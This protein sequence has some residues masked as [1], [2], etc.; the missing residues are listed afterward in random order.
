MSPSTGDTMLDEMLGGGVPAGRTLLVRGPSGVGKSR[1]AMGFLDA[2]ADA[3]EDCLYVTTD[4]PLSVARA[5]LEPADGVTLAAVHRDTSGGGVRFVTA[6]A[7][8]TIPFGSLIERLTESDWSRLAVDGAGGLVDLA[9]DRER[10]RHGRFHLLERLDEHETT[11]VLTATP[12]ASSAVARLAHGVLDCWREEIEGDA[13]PFCRVEKLRGRDHD[14][15]RHA[16]AHDDDGVTVSAREWATHEDPFR[17]GIASLD[18]LTG[19]FV[20]NGTTLFEHDGTADHWPFSA[21]LAARAVE[22]DAPV[23]VVTAPGTLGNRV[24]DLLSETV[25]P[26]T[27]LMERNLLYLIDPVSRSPGEPAVAGLETDSVVLQEAEGSIQEAFRTLVAELGG[28]VEEAV[29]IIEHS[30]MAHLVTENEA[31]QLYYWAD[32]NVMNG[33]YDLTLV[34]TIDRAVAGDRLTAFFSGAADQVVRTWRGDDELQY[35]SVPKSPAGTPGHTR[36]VE[37]LEAPPY[38]ELR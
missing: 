16:L 4:E 21:A 11:A 12:A 25:A 13:R 23:V 37:P 28:R 9:P 34:L 17:T 24:D 15:R 36:V 31:R 32:G 1:L 27:E 29:A 33:E 2:G 7:S 6:E 10:G 14:T 5:S 3:G 8:E 30:A 19:G 38:V 35:L 18:E 26:V 20:R 22:Q